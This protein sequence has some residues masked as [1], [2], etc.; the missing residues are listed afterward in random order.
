MAIS[1]LTSDTSTTF[2]SIVSDLASAG[3]SYANRVSRCAFHSLQQTVSSYYQQPTP[4]SH[5]FHPVTREG[6]V[7]VNR[8]MEM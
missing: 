2:S 7:L 4:F 3:Y 8:T 5:I 1:R 6:F